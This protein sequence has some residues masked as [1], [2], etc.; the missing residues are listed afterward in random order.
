[1]QTQYLKQKLNLILSQD[2]QPKLKD[3][4]FSV[5]NQTNADFESQAGRATALLEL[6]TD[7]CVAGKNKIVEMDQAFSDYSGINEAYITANGSFSSEAAL[8]EMAKTAIGRKLVNEKT[9][10]VIRRISFEDSHHAYIY[11]M[12]IS[13]MKAWLFKSGNGKDGKFTVKSA[14]YKDAHRIVA[15]DEGLR[16]HTH[17]VEIGPPDE[18]W[19]SDG[20]S[21]RTAESYWNYNKVIYVNNMSNAQMNFYFAHVNG[22]K[23]VSALNFDIP[24]PGIEGSWC[25]ESTN[26]NVGHLDIDEVP[27]ENADL[28]WAWIMDYVVLNRLQAQFAACFETLGAAAF[29][30]NWSNQESCMWQKSKLRFSF[31]KFSPTRAILRTALEGAPYS[32]NTMENNFIIDEVQYYRQFILSSSLLNYYMWYGLY[33]LLTNELVGTDDWRAVCQGLT[34]VTGTLIRPEMRAYAITAVTGQE[35]PTM[36]SPGANLT[37]AYTD[38]IECR[39]LDEVESV[40]DSPGGP[41]MIDRLYAPVSGSLMLGAFGGE[42]E[43]VEHLVATQKFS[44]KKEETG[45]LEDTEA[46]RLANMYRL[47]G[48]DTAFMNEHGTKVKPWGNVREAVLE[49]GSMMKGSG[50][51]LM[52]E[53]FDSTARAGRHYQL[54]HILNAVRTGCT[55]TVYRPT[56][57]ITEYGSRTKTLVVRKELVRRRR[58]PVFTVKAAYVGAP[59]PLRATR[60]GEAVGQGFRDVAP[61]TTPSVPAPGVPEKEA[62][63]PDPVS[64]ESEGAA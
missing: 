2:F 49:R 9:D 18:D 63:E 52:Y 53:A 59:Q 44:A 20:V 50:A 24:L 1:M 55:M 33:A 26:S 29:Q 56:L 31:A 54:P 11:N 60:R 4:R 61:G 8:A 39:Q 16:D 34:Q 5:V 58:T 64:I 40:D 57:R 32:R 17:V 46:F 19:N 28:M 37:I 43:A 27:W 21:E 51:I 42:L 38:V 3:G 48:H 41:I 45:L 15:L 30:P 12:L 7:F 35:M 25:F 47:F 62:V 23:S 36:M 22:R 14:P 6:T 10:T 13:W